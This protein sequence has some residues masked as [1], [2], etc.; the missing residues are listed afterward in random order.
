MSARLAPASS[1]CIIWSSRKLHTFFVGAGGIASSFVHNGQGNTV[2]RPLQ[3]DVQGN[4]IPHGFNSAEDFQQFGSLLRSEL[5]DGTQPLFQ[6]S[7]VTGSSYS[8]G[9]PFD[10]GRQSDFDI[11]LAGSDLFEKAKALNL[12]TKD[13]SRI[14]PLSAKNLEDL[15]L[16][17]LQGQLNGL[18]GRSVEFMLFDSIES[19]LKRPSIWVP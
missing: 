19:A 12:K 5:P 15:G 2:K 1:N 17:V 14:G 13:G 7:A 8:T 9:K 6:G 16:S 18:A 11:A 3:V 10:V 4:P